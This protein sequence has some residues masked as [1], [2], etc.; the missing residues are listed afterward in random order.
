MMR[1]VIGRA[2]SPLADSATTG[3]AGGSPAGSATTGRAGGSPAGLADK[4]LMI[5]TAR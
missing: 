5:A 1:I 2:G 3:R 4:V